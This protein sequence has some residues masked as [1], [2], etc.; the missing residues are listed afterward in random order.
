MRLPQVG[1]EGQR[2]LT[3]AR[4]AVVG[5]G[6]TGS[7]IADALAR[8]GVG[9]LRLIDR[10]IVEPSNL[11]RQVLYTDADALAARPKAVC[12]AERLA[13]VNPAIEVEAVCADLH[14]DNVREHLVGMTCVADGTDNFLTRFVVNDFCVREAIPWVY[15]GAVGVGGHCMTVLPQN[16][17]LRCYVP[18][19]PA[20][21]ATA[22]CSSAGVLGPAVTMVGSLAATQLLR[23]LLGD[24]V[25]GRL[26]VA[27]VWTGT[28]RWLTV[29]PDPQCP[30]CAKRDFPFLTTLVSKRAAALCGRN[31]VHVPA[32]S[33]SP[34]DLC[35]LAER[36]RSLGATDVRAVDRVLAFRFSALWISVFPDGR[37]IVKGTDDVGRARSVYAQLLGG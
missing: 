5:V 35:V 15:V 34:V 12:A 18:D 17:C 1:P 28:I 37:A 20:P 25:G 23:I 19:L 22:T 10:D 2:V 30:C 9:F 11:Q 14:P 6:A 16:S 31:S 32:V 36:V 21:G 7:A 26:A 29:A 24:A 3:A 8:A 4:V 33:G 27:D 13:A